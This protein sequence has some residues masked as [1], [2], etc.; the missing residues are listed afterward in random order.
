MVLVERGSSV[1][2]S[3]RAEGLQGAPEGVVSITLACVV[4]S[5]LMLGPWLT[6]RIWPK[7]TACEII[8]LAALESVVFLGAMM[9]VLGLMVI[10]SH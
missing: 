3:L 9:L 6:V 4:T 1:T 5:A 10:C 2:P 8:Y 7:S